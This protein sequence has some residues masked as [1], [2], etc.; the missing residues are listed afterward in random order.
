VECLIRGKNGLSFAS[1]GV[2]SRCFWLGTCISSFS[3]SVLCFCSVSCAQCCMCLQLS[4]AFRSWVR[5]VHFVLLYG[6]TFL[7]PYCV[8]RYDSRIKSDVQ[9]EFSPSCLMED[10]CIIYVICVCFSIVVS[11]ML[12]HYMSLCS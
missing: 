5:V 12:S 10:S 8:F 2:H 11:N 1:T 4:P 6:F 3:F 9:F 7:V